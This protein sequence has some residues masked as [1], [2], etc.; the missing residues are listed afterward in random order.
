MFH[1]LYVE[2]FLSF[3]LIYFLLILLGT[4]DLIFRNVVQSILMV[5]CSRL[6]VCI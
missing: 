6:F 4:D 2:S 5:L 3:A 1:L